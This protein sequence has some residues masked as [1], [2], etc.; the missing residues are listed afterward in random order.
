MLLIINAICASLLTKSKMFAFSIAFSFH[1]SYL[2]FEL[3][4]W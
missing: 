2:P 4:C 3:E 1:H